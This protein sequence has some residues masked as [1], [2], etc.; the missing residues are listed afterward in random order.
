RFD[1]AAAD[2]LDAPVVRHFG[3][4][5][6]LDTTD[7]TPTLLPDPA[8]PTDPI[9][10]LFTPP[11]MATAL[12]HPDWSLQ[13]DGERL[14]VLREI[15]PAANRDEWL[16]AAMTVRAALLAAAAN[17]PAR[18][19]P[20]PPLRTFGQNAA[21]VLGTVG[22]GVLGM[23]GGFF[24]FA[25]LAMPNG[26]VILPFL[27]AAGGGLAGVLIG[28]ALGVLAGWLPAVRNMKPVDPAEQKRRSNRWVRVG[29]CLGF[30]AGFFGGGVAFMALDVLVFGPGGPNGWLALF[31]VLVFGGGFAGL[32]AGGMLGSRIARRT[33]NSTDE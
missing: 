12:D 11:L 32:V 5:F 17:P 19:L 24:G 3:R 25:P 23:F 28:F 16:T 2:P 22:G 8:P 14:A 21:R 4:A 31:P 15:R 6:R 27:G 33:D 13:C 9:R 29:G 7:V 10:R 26:F 1:P 18:E 20:S 30:F